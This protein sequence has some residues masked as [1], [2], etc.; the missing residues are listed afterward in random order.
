M[1][2]VSIIMNFKNNSITKVIEYCKARGVTT[3]V[4]PHG[5]EIKG[6]YFINIMKDTYYHENFIHTAYVALEFLN[7]KCN[8][9]VYTSICVFEN[10]EFYMG[11]YISSLNK[12]SELNKPSIEYIEDKI[13]PGCTMCKFNELQKHVPSDNILFSYGQYFKELK[14]Y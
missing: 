8:R 1:V 7:P 6:K 5:I 3:E 13:I 14:C 9:Y 10:N 11:D 12:Y 4:I 2:D